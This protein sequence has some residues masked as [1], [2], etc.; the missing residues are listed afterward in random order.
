MQYKDS[1]MAFNM[2]M[3][4]LQ[5]DIINGSVMREGKKYKYFLNLTI[6]KDNNP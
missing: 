3:H 2:C 4:T 5:G 6:S 1:E